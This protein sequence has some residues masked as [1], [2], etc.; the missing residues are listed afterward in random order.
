MKAVLVAI[1]S[2]LASP[3][4]WTRGAYARDVY[5]QPVSCIRPSACKWCLAG[6]LLADDMVGGE[7][8]WTLFTRIVNERGFSDIA[9]FN[10]DPLTTYANVL[11]VLDEAISYAK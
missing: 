9:T 11:Q 6:A 10:D 4:A 5:N 3:D 1:K 7:E 8:C 2:R